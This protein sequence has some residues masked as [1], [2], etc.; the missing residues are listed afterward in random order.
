MLSLQASRYLSEG[1]GS[2]AIASPVARAGSARVK[3]G[4]NRLRAVNAILAC[5]L[6]I[7]PDTVDVLS[8]F[9]ILVFAGSSSADT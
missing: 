5:S 7:S 2:F 1:V 8:V 4:K 9:A 6:K 3:K